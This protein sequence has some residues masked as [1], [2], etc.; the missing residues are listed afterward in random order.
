MVEFA[1]EHALFAGIRDRL[2]DIPLLMADSK[3]LTGSDLDA[4]TAERA[5]QFRQQGAGPGRWI[6]LRVPPAIETVVD[7]LALWRCGAGAVLLDPQHPPDW[8]A[9]LVGGTGVAGVWDAGTVG[10]QAVWSDL[11]AMLSGA[12]VAV[13]SSG[14]ESRPRAV[15][16]DL[17][18]L[19]FAA[20]S[21]AARLGM[22]E[23]SVIPLTLPLHHVSGL[24][25]LIRALVSGAA[26]RL[27]SS[28]Q[29][30]RSLLRAGRFT[31][32]SLVAAQLIHVLENPEMTDS[33]RQT[34]CVL[35]GGAPTSD[36]LLDRAWQMGIP[37]RNSYGMTETA[38]MIA[39]TPPGENPAGQ[40]AIPL[41]PGCVALDAT[42]RIMVRGP[43]LFR[44][45]LEGGKV[46]PPQLTHEGWYRTGD[47]GELDAR[48]R[49]NVRGRAD[50]VIISGG[51]KIHPERLTAALAD[52]PGVRAAW[53]L[54][55]PDPT[56]GEVPA[57][58]LAMAAGYTLPTPET[59]WQNIGKTFPAW[60][61]LRYVWPW[62][63]DVCAPGP[64][65][66]LRALRT[67]ALARLVAETSR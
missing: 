41:Y 17:D 13:F 52:L 58:I 55:V 39:V 60:M 9:G 62:P 29:G 6:G 15:V 12:G 50:A 59:V 24:M 54:G 26:I 67:W 3:V 66:P 65:P 14:T 21:G 64:K 31:H 35:L 25:T 42:E 38:A 2:T 28:E 32:V 49:L 63:E 45:W 43:M 33:L 11:P 5:M 16:H 44:G 37:V 8:E 4:M 10:D 34:R 53:V 51:E 56:Y 46:V 7:L 20:R 48:G 40:G 30:W 23:G 1:E 57:A 19:G 36:T 18:T 22:G 47:T 27:V 61:R